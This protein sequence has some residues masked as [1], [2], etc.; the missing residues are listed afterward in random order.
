MYRSSSTHHA[1]QVNLKAIIGGGLAI[2]GG[3]SLV[4][5]MTMKDKYGHPTHGLNRV[6]RP[7][8]QLFPL[9]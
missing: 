9:K 5:D 8:S 2:I 7:P 6:L 1:V 4:A 3:G